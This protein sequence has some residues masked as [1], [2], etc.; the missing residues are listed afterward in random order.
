[1]TDGSA[2]TFISQ[3]LTRT[4][5]YSNTNTMA[6]DQTRHTRQ[7]GQNMA[8]A[9]PYGPQ[10]GGHDGAP[11]HYT[12]AQHDGLGGLVSQFSGMSVAPS[13]VHQGA[14]MA[15]PPSGYMGTDVPV[16]FPTYGGHPVHTGMVLPPDAYFAGGLTG[17]AYM[18]S[19]V[20]A[21]F[22][23][24]ILP[25]TPGRAA[26]YG[27]DRGFQRELPGLENRRASY[28]TTATE[29]TPG[30]PFFGAM[31]GDVHKTR[32]LSG[33]RSSYTTP[34][35]QQLA[36]SGMIGQVTP[37][38]KRIAEADLRV[39][40]ELD[41]AI[42]AA[43]PAVFTTPEQRKSLDQCLEN[44][45]EGNKNCYI[46]GL[47]PTTDDD[48]LLKFC[49][50]FGEVEQSKAIIDTATGACKGYVLPLSPQFDTFRG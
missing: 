13:N 19:N 18:Q 12:S 38:C 49:L 43:V 3:E 2:N 29:S 46:R 36:V 24:Y 44:R 28:S 16:G 40:M 21:A 32:I 45:I 9:A 5:S 20:P 35:P 6:G 27:G 23:S 34:S 30:T 42:P 26:S 22:G 8:P 10:G 15:M 17:N 1:M 14:H 4:M 25:Y 7:N 33:D 39:L 37:K 41:P 50:R 11:L 48:L 31:G 47:H